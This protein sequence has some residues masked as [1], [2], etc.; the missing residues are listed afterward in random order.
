MVQTYDSG[1]IIAATSDSS[2]ILNVRLIKSDSLGFTGCNEQTSASVENPASTISIDSSG[3]FNFS[4]YPL[5]SSEFIINSTGTQQNICSSIGIDEV[6][7]NLKMVI[8]PNPATDFAIVNTEAFGPAFNLQVYDPL[9][10]LIS[11]FQIK[12]LVREVSID[13][14]EFSSGIYFIRASSDAHSWSG[15]VVKE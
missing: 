10:N 14:S 4:T 13:L 15:K 11:G 9:G 8:Y 7:R 12:S 1:F 2:D 5:N 3:I 6:Q